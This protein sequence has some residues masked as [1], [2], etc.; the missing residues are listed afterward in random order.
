MRSDRPALYWVY[1][2][3]FVYILHS[4]TMTP[5]WARWRLKS[6][7]SRLFTQPFIQGADQRKHKAPRHW[8][9]WGEFTGD[10]WIPRTKSQLRGKCFHLMKSSWD[11]WYL[12]FC[13]FLDIDDCSPNPCQNGGTC[14]DLVNG[15]NCQCVPGF[16]GKQCDNSKLNGSLKHL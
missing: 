3:A 6:P 8:P 13:L 4:I 10:Q 16:V 1:C 2:N 9:L 7:A 15:F 14:E 12:N 5:Q 11:R